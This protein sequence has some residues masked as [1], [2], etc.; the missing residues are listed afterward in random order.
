[1]PTVNVRYIVD[2]VDAG[3]AWYTKHLGFTLLQRRS[4]IR[5]RHARLVT[6]LAQW[7]D[8]LGRT[9]YARRRSAETRRLESHS[10]HR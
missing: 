4:R 9:A 10:P 3:V 7:A 2:D 5:G 6:T 1:M 8:E